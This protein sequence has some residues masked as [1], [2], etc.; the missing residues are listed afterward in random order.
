MLEFNDYEIGDI[1]ISNNPF[2]AYTIPQVLL[3]KKRAVDVDV[4]RKIYGYSSTKEN[5]QFTRDV[6]ILSFMLAGMNVADMFNCRIKDN[7]IEYERQKTKGRRK[8]QAFISVY[9]HPLAMNIIQKYDDGTG[10][11]IFDAVGKYGDSRNVT[12]AVHRGLKKICTDLGIDYIQ[13][14]SA[15]HSF[16]T[17]ARNECGFGKDDIAVCLN[18]SSRQSVTDSYIKEDYSVIERVVRKVIG[19]TFD[20]NSL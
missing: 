16:A 18:H 7:H 3:P 13:F 19:F 6:Y 11:T 1:V 15:R 10:R 4:I 14:Y 20:I 5:I 12:K 8:D 2:K 9:V 17:I